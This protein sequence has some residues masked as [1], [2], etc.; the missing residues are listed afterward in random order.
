[1]SLTGGI[2]RDQIYVAVTSASRRNNDSM[3]NLIVLTSIKTN[4]WSKAV[5]FSWIH[6]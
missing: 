5:A 3:C 2:S 1:M 6:R 4:S